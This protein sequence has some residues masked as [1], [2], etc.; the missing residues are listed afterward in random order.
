MN[1]G[2][3]TF[4]PPNRSNDLGIF[5]NL[6][7]S[8]MGQPEPVLESSHSLDPGLDLP[9]FLDVAQQDLVP[10]LQKAGSTSFCP[11]RIHNDVMNPDRTL[12]HALANSL[13]Y[14]P[15]YLLRLWLKILKLKD[16]RR[17]KKVNCSLLSHVCVAAKGL[18][19]LQHHAILQHCFYCSYYGHEVKSQSFT[20]VVEITEQQRSKEREYFWKLVPKESCLQIFSS[21]ICYHLIKRTFLAGIFT[22]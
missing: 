3:G 11:I 5:F 7:P 6:Y 22:F 10:G 8:S 9:L 21:F 4:F 16:K 14:K 18:D 15:V 2:T 17:T 13:S 19:Q 12:K 1:T 20:K